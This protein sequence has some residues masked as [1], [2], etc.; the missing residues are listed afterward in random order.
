MISYYV[1]DY[2]HYKVEVI[3]C[4]KLG[5]KAMPHYQD[6]PFAWNLDKTLR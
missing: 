4:C 3:N 1:I 6:D 5:R 2:M